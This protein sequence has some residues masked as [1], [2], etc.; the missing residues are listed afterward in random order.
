M[1][2]RQAG[3]PPAA[4]RRAILRLARRDHSQAELRRAL[5]ERGYP[6]DEVDEAIARLV[7][8]R[9]LDDSGYAARFARSRLAHHGLGR[10]RIR[11]ALRQRGVGRREV[12]AGLRSALAEVDEKAVV[13]SLARRYWKAHARVEPEKRL[14]RLWAFLLR[15]GFAP[16]LVKERLAELWPRWS[17]ALEGLEPLEEGEGR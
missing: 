2:G 7:R 6:Q 5:L 13:D 4:Y 9:C 15:R 3:V 14:P 1:P 8:E 11:Q 12:E 10:T 16:A 17:D